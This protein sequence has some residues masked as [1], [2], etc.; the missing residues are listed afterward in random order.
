MKTK[1]LWLATVA[2]LFLLVT[3]MSSCKD[4]NVEVI[5]VC[6]LVISTNPANLAINVPLNQIITAT[7]NEEMNP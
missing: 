2:S 1:R 3:F 5:G 4:E 6:P 7:F